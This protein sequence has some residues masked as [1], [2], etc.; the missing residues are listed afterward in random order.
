MGDE[1]NR[2]IEKTINSLDNPTP[3][4]T[5]PYFY[6]RL[7]LR[8]EE[9]SKV[10]TSWKWSLAATVLL[11]ILNATFILNFW[12]D[13]A[14]ETDPIEALAGEYSATWPSLYDNDFIYENE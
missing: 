12:P 14:M 6:S 4:K 7:K 8:M 11:V 2:E 5:D 1:L 9:E 10:A 3:L 13:N